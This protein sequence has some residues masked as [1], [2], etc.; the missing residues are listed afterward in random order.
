MR[1]RLGSRA[2]RAA[3]LSPKILLIV[4]AP[5]TGSSFMVRA[6]V[7]AAGFA[8]MAEG[9]VTPLIAAVDQTVADYFARMRA[10][11]LLAIP[12]NTIARIPEAYLRRELLAVFESFDKVIFPF[13]RHILDKTVNAEG[14]AALPHL[15]SIWPESKILYLK[16]DGVENVVS[17]EKY[18]DL[19]LDGACTSWAACGDTWD[20]VRAQLPESSYI[21]VDHW[22][23]TDEPLKVADRIARHL[24]LPPAASQRFQNYVAENTRDWRNGRTRRPALAA[25]DW[26]A[27]RL[28]RFL[29]ICGKQMVSQGYAS[30]QEVDSL[31]ASKKQ[32]AVYLAQG[33][34]Q[35]LP[36]GSNV[37]V[38][39]GADSLRISVAP[40]VTSLISYDGVDT[41]GNR[42]L[43][44]Q[45][46]IPDAREDSSLFVNVVTL[47]SATGAAFV[48]Q[49]STL[50]AAAPLHFALHLPVTS[51]RVDVLIRLRL[52]PDS[53][54]GLPCIVEL[55]DLRFE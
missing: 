28:Y 30:Q 23:L 55:T 51:M 47:D 11:G 21:E 1:A 41:G 13:A 37:A 52:E 36:G 27:Q 9:H 8:G 18:F 25:L 49:G 5:R 53:G 20:R 31:L 42:M 50:D 7:N 10:L 26:P 6:L 44:G 46:A 22:Q 32:S 24:E 38:D 17:T 14:I 54:S 39:A 33:S 29:T 3:R 16:R 2:A 40:G 19:A 35:V 48:A 12:Q 43:A 4:G 45:L 34:A 15:L